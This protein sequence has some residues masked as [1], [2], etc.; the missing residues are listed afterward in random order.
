MN[1]PHASKRF[2]RSESSVR[3]LL[4]AVAVMVTTASFAC[5]GDITYTWQDDSKSGASGFLEIDSAAQAAGQFT[6]ADVVNFDFFAGTTFHWPFFGLAPSTVPIST[7]NAGFTSPTSSLFSSNAFAAFTI[8]IN[9]NYSIINGESWTV[10]GDVSPFPNSGTGHWVITGAVN[11]VP[12]PT[13]FVPAGIAVLVGLAAWRRR[14][15]S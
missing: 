1:V 5:A 6:A 2:S 9:S 13:S 14:K 3:Q 15:A 7:E 4:L 8:D 11:G 12:E 10:F